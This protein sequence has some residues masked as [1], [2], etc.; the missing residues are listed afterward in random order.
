MPPR[1]V[2]LLDE[3]SRQH[4]D[5][6]PPHGIAQ[7]RKRGA[8]AFVPWLGEA[9]CYRQCTIGP[10]GLVQSGQA[11]GAGGE[12]LPDPWGQRQSGTI[13]LANSAPWPRRVAVAQVRAPVRIDVHLHE[14][15]RKPQCVI[16]G[17]LLGH[18]VATR[19]NL[20]AGNE[21]WQCRAHAR[22]RIGTTLSATSVAGGDAA[23]SGSPATSAATCSAQWLTASRWRCSA[24]SR[25]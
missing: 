12:E 11:V 5:L 13:R 6:P 1:L 3:A 20:T 7:L 17:S 4:R 16:G 9:E 19:R 24:E 10:H 8:R 23:S 22:T 15:W 18:V 14:R 21:Q 25:S 2:A